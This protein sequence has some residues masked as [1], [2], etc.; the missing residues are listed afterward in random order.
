MPKSRYTLDELKMR[1]D[2]V[3]RHIGPGEPQIQEMLELLGHSSLEGLI[4]ET[5]PDAIRIKQPLDLGG[6][7][8]GEDP[9]G[10]PAALE[11]FPIIAREGLHGVVTVDLPAET[12]IEKASLD[13]IVALLQTEERSCTT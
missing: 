3:R 2:F 8:G 1:G 4:D 12:V 10:H 11:E 6:G 7:A 13:D 9:Q 5:V